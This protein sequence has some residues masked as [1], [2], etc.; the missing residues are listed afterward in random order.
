[1]SDLF[2]AAGKPRPFPDG[3]VPRPPTVWDRIDVGAPDACWPYLGA[4]S[5][6]YGRHIVDTTTKAT[7]AAH[8]LAYESVHGPV[9][10]GLV[11]DHLCRNRGCCNPAHLEPV[12]SGENTRR[13]YAP[14][15]INARKT[16]CKNGHELTPENLCDQAD[17]RRRCRICE[18]EYRRQHY[19]AN[20]AHIRERENRR[21]RGSTNA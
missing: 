16:H 19:A 2:T 5:Y 13:G 4:T 8:R 20:R 21:R 18:R 10:D 11:L 1:M 12:T 6:G 7:R 17:G 3:Q 15:A 14:A 9:P